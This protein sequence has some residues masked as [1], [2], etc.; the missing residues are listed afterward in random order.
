ML[1]AGYESRPEANIAPTFEANILASRRLGPRAVKPTSSSPSVFGNDRV[2]AVVAAQSAAD[3][4]GQ[5]KAAGSAPGR[6]HV[7]ELRLDF[8]SDRVEIARLL[9]WL[10]R[11]D[12]IPTLI[13]TCRLRQAGGRFK[14]RAA[15]E[16]AVLARAVAAGCRWCDIEIETAEE[17]GA[18][19]LKDALAPARLLISAH[20]FRRLPQNLPTIVRRLEAYGGDAIKIA[21]ASRSLAEVRQLLEL[22]RGRPDVVVVPMGDGMLAARLLALR[23]GGALAYAPMARST[24]PGQIP[25]DEIERVYRLRRRFGKSKAGINPQT[26]LY[27]VIGNPV[28]HSF[29][30]LMHNAAFAARHKNAI[31]LPF[32]VRDLS[33][34]IAAI[35]PFQIAG[36]SVTLPHKERILRDLDECDTLAAEI[37]AV[38]TVVVRAGKLCGYNTDFT[39]VLRA[40]ERRLP[41][42]SSSVLLVGAGG[43]AR[44]AAFALARAGGA[45]S[46]WARR[47]QRARALARAV[48]GEAIDRREIARRS[49]D[50]IVNCTPVGMHP[51]GGSP[52]E[53]RELNCRLVMDLIYRPLKTEL[54]R[55]AE[56]QGIETISGV[57]MFVAQG[58]SQWEL[59]IGESAPKA[60][61]RR[62]VLAALQ[63]EEKS[64][65]R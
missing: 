62:A 40:I 64:L 58:V 25:F 14:G 59:W 55:R 47:P 61:M 9:G 42:S 39:G 2:C 11:Q 32:H 65:R 43:A 10:A 63:K 17:V 6:A 48:G 38:N 37:G 1:P 7:V 13:A 8:L 56:R 33:D 5:V 28:A 24:A 3:A 18:A 20:D 50:A 21:A 49:F 12:K 16:I 52:L 15:D 41:L 27:G 54:L 51:G 29:S 46:I 53:G 35:E 34:F 36:F 44:A 23:Q 22:A 31:Y 57:D 26:S 45:V 4:I 19:Q 30:P 60:V